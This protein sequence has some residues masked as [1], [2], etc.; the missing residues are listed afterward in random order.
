LFPVQDRLGSIGK[1]YPWGQEKP[2]ATTNNTEKFTAYFRDAETGL[3]YA[4]N[5]Y[6]QPGMGRFL[7][8]DPKRWSA[9]PNL[10]GS[11][12]RYAYVAGDPIN[13][14]DRKGLDD[15]DGDRSDD[16]DACGDD[17][18][19]DDGGA[20][21]GD[22][23]NDGPLVDDGTLVDDTSVDVT[24][25]GSTLDGTTIGIG[26]TGTISVGMPCYFGSC[27]TQVDDPPTG[28]G[29]FGSGVTDCNNALDEL[30][31]ATANVVARVEDIIPYGKPDPGHKKALKQAVQRLETALKKAVSSCKS[32]A[33]AG[34]LAAAVAAALDALAEAAPYLVIVVLL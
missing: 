14:V 31:K 26:G 17:N 19:G 9:K 1:F 20:P 33:T 7:T 3:D 28:T 11:W 8:P 23:S 21:G 27:G 2:S 16:E 30:S 6:H 15:C 29:F 25:T 4:K 22:G 24:D 32:V 5:R 12:N 18:G 10:P 34:A 13:R